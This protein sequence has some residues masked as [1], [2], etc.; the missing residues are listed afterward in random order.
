ML[1]ALDELLAAVPFEPF[2][3]K[4][5]NGDSFDIVLQE[6]LVIFRDQGHAFLAMSHGHWA[7]F[8]LAFISSF[9][10]LLDL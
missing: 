6:A 5:I 8:R 3:I 1:E 4:M 2:R 10:S 7:T 9:E